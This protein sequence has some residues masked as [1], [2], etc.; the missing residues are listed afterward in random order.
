MFEQRSEMSFQLKSIEQGTVRKLALSGIE[1]K[2]EGFSVFQD[3]FSMK[4]HSSGKREIEND[5]EKTNNITMFKQFL[6]RT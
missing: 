6:I 3:E 5:F 4:L 2:T 1:H